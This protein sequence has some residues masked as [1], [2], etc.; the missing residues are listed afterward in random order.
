M[1]FHK[2]IASHMGCW[3]WGSRFWDV[4]PYIPVQ[5]YWLAHRQG[6]RVGQAG[7]KKQQQA[8]IISCYLLLACSLLDLLFNPEDG[9]SM[10]LVISEILPKC[11]RNI[12][13]F[14]AV[15]CVGSWFS[16]RKYFWK[17]LLPTAVYFCIRYLPP[18]RVAA[19]RVQG[20]FWLA[21]TPCMTG[22]R[23]P[24]TTILNDPQC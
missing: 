16:G 20:W 10:F 18:C 6:L 8:E 2:K 22:G 21:A 17:N 13:G 11:T 23:L 3:I 14:P 5:F 1:W 9:G 4:T 24:S 19:D 15:G 7:N 12:L